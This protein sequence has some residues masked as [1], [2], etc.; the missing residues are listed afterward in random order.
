[1]IMSM[2]MFMIMSML[3]IITAGRHAARRALPLP[4]GRDV[5]S[6]PAREEYKQYHMT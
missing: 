4:R 2:V 3:I 5:V 6:W 1:M